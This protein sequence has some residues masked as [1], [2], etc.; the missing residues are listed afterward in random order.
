[1]A[2]AISV[3]H[4]VIDRGDIRAVNDISF[5]VEAGEVLA[6]LGPNGA[7][8]SSTVETLEGYLAP[9]AG[10]VSVLGLDPMGDRRTLRP[11][12]G[13]ML[14]RGGIYPTLSPAQALSLFA[15]YY[16]TAMNPQ[17]LIERL[18]LRDVAKTPW[19]RLSGGEQQRTSLALALIGQPKV[20]FLDDPT[21]GV[22]IHGRLAIREVIGEQAATGVAVL[23]TTHEL[24]EAEIVA[25]RIAIMNRG[26]LQRSGRT[27]DLIETGVRFT[28]REGLDVAALSQALGAPVREGLPGRYRVDSE[29]TSEL[30]AKL[31]EFLASH[32]S[33]LDQL[34]AGG[35]LEELYLSLVGSDADHSAGTPSRS[36]RRR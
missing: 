16:D 14:Q 24:S 20:L 32:D 17:H 26:Q 9:Q 7:G 4:L 18:G 27:V 22:D 3:E 10:S 8:K 31:N 2:T 34:S 15:S 25:D 23:L 12:I 11:Q 19:R 28:S 35:S 21:A 30:I 13:V 5:S 33:R 36:R 6:L 29:S 1:M